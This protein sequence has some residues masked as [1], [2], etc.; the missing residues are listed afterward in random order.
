MKRN[1]IQIF[2]VAIAILFS[3][4]FFE[5][6]A[7]SQTRYYITANLNLRAA[8]STT[9]PVITTIPKGTAIELAYKSDSEWIPV[10]YSGHIGYVSG[11]YI[12]NQRP[13][14]QSPIKH[15]TNTYGNR[16]QSPTRYS[17]R[18][19][20]ATALCRDGS[21]SFSETRCGTCSHHGGVQQWY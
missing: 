20:N 6:N 16:V 4:L 21:Y 13:V 11:K 2:K 14:A 5:H 9:A 1:Q 10:Y 12:S 15:Y 17:S 18:P 3:L 8:P 19:S 7:C